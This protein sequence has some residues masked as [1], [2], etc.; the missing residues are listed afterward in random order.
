MNIIG[1][2]KG[3][4]INTPLSSRS[5]PK[6]GLCRKDGGLWRD[7]FGVVEGME[8]V[9]DHHVPVVLG[10]RFTP[11]SLNVCQREGEVHSP[12]LPAASATVQQLYIH[13]L[14]F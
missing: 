5:E 14:S 6:Y 11:F 13:T 9:K 7:G 10:E 8:P 4:Q 3:L 1:N 12:L 2:K